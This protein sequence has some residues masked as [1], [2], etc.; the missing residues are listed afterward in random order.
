MMC[1]GETGSIVGKDRDSNLHEIGAVPE[2][3]IAIDRKLRCD[4]EDVV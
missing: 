1:S 2:H 3:L 4:K